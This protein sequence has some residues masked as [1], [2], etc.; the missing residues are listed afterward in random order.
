MTASLVG[1]DRT[2]WLTGEVHEA[3]EHYARY[4]FHRGA[5]V[6]ADEG[7]IP[8]AGPL[9]TA[10]IRNADPVPVHREPRKRS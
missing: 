6:L 2:D 4:L 1:E 3:T 7:S 8:P 9:T 5:A 10:S